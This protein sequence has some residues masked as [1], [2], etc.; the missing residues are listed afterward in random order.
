MKSLSNMTAAIL[1]GGLG[2][3]LRPVMA[4]RPK[5]L[6]EVGGRPLIF[7]LLDQLAAAGIQDVVL[8][9]GYL[10]HQVKE[11]LGESHGPL[12]LIYS[13]ESS[14]LGTGGALRLA[15]P[16]FLTDQVLILNGDSFCDANLRALAL[17][18]R[19][20]T[21]K[22]T[23]LEKGRKR[24]PGWI[25]AGIYLIDRSLL[26]TIPPDQSVS[27]E[28]ESFPAWVGQG[29]YGFRSNGRF[30]DIGTPES[31]ALAQDFFHQEIQV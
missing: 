31:F 1:A 11:V 10:G 4:D 8:C 14:P 12:R 20:R 30:V 3:R 16:L 18:H 15:L 6:A 19:L 26:Q 17:I 9:T 22:A 2:T 27:L 5:V 7:Y 21:A 29:L 28:R 25:N 24:G 13:Q 23:I